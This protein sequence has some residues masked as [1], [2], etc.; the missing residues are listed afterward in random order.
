VAVP[1]E[2]VVTRSVVL[3]TIGVFNRGLTVI[4]QIVLAG[5]FGQSPSADAYFATEAI[6]DLFILL[7]G[8]GLSMAAIP[9]YS[10]LRSEAV[11]PLPPVRVTPPHTAFITS[12]AVTTT[13]ML[14]AVSV[15]VSL[16]APVVVSVLAPGFD[17]GTRSLAIDLLR[18]MALV[19][20]LLATDAATRAAL[21]CH[22]RFA[23]PELTRTAYN[24]AVLAAVLLF[25]DDH[26]VMAIGWGMVVG[27]ALMSS[28]QLI[29]AARLKLISR[30][31]L[32]LHPEAVEILARIPAVLLVLAWPLVMLLV[33]RAAASDAQSGTLAALGYAT[34]VVFLPVG[35]IVVPLATVLYPRLS[36]LAT[37]DDG[38]DLARCVGSG[39]R[40]MLYLVLLPCAVLAVARA[41]VVELLFQR[42][43]FDAEATARTGRA[44]ALY[45]LS[46]PGFAL[47]FF[48]RNAYLALG[49]A[50]TLA[51]MSAVSLGLGA[52]MNDVLSLALGV[53]GIIVATALVTTATA[54]V[55]TAYLVHSCC[56]PLPVGDLV[57]STL[58]MVALAAA[59]ATLL[60]LVH[61]WLL[62]ATGWRPLMLRLVL[63]G[64]ALVAAT[65]LYVGG[66]HL[67]G[68][69]ES[70]ELMARLGQLARRGR[71][72]WP[73]P[74]PLGWRRVGRTIA[75]RAP[76]NVVVAGLALSGAAMA[77]VVVALAAGVLVGLEPYALALVV[78]GPLFVWSLVR[79]YDVLVLAAFAL[80]GVVQPEPAP[81]DFLM[82]GLIVVGL[83]T[84]RLDFSRLR[85]QRLVNGLVWALVIATLISVFDAAESTTSIRFTIITLYCIAIMYFV[86]TY[87][88]GPADV[89]RMFTG[90]LL[91]AGVA[92]ALVLADLVGLFPDDIVMEFDRARGLTQDSNV[93]GPFLIPLLVVLVD[94]AWR[95]RLLPQI[96]A[97]LK[98]AAAAA[99]VVAVFLTF[100]RAAWGNLVL[101]GVLYGVLSRRRLTARERRRAIGGLMA[102]GVGL[103]VL[104]VA[105]GQTSFLADRATLIQGY[106]SERFE[107]Q[108]TGLELGLSSLTGIGPGMMDVGDL[109]SPHNLYIRALAETG[110]LG[111]VTLVALI[112]CVMWPALRI[113]TSDVSVAG[114]S[115]AVLVA[116][117]AGQLANSF[118]IDTVHWRH[119]WFLLGLVWLIDVDRAS[120]VAG[121]R[122]ATELVGS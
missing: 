3:S 9:V 96:G 99:T 19:L 57:R 10:R 22:R 91:G 119:F 107:A 2:R 53:D 77:G 21:N 59:A 73:A 121:S 110:I 94:D 55:L 111:L 120:E 41:E 84:G 71:S 12:Y 38:N 106:D 105:S 8:G 79:H 98:L 108:Q 85:G 27:A 6:P 113:R 52:V 87:V 122:P 88:S 67:L 28:I 14:T 50:W 32:R 35:I 15:L 104:I 66:G 47:V 80:F 61:D 24:L 54:L 68:L 1:G 95:P 83:V 23:I 37:N 75:D 7:I 92:V 25:T 118:L 62:T 63:L 116:V 42:G 51:W 114:L 117:T 40:T 46:I 16:A 26:G 13:A 64:P 56:M 60:D 45:S 78:G 103:Y 76:I 97:R 86:R 11:P 112:A 33:D 49:R 30:P 93:F 65:A 90:Y 43:L 31:R 20:M 115:P 4:T 5:R 100:S 82:A 89:A 81:V 74:P 70:R 17:P 102:I 34:R 48:L 101:V 29:W 72:C 39:L 36:E 69:E 44:V 18:V 109:F 58:T